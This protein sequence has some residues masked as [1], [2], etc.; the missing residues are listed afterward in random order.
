[1]EYRYGV[2][3]KT[4]ETVVK[5]AV[6]SGTTVVY[7]GT[8]PV[9][10]IRGYTDVVNTPVKLSN[11]EN[12][13]SRIGFSDDWENF[14][15]SEAV[16]AHFNN[17]K[18]NVG[19]VYAINVLDPDTHRKKEQTTVS[20]AFTNKKAY[21]VS[22]TIILDTLA[23]EGMTEGKD[24]SVSYSYGK[25]TV[26]IT[27]LTSMEN[28][29]ATYY[30]VNT[31]MIEDTDIIGEYTDGT[32]TGLKAVK[33]IYS[34]FNAVTN[35][36]AVPKWSEKQSVYLEMCRSS[37]EINGHWNA[38]ALAD[39]PVSEGTISAAVSWKSDNGYQ[40]ENSKVFWPKAKGID[41]KIYHLST[42]AAVEFLRTDNEHNGIPM[43]TCGNKKVPMAAQWFGK[44]SNNN[45]FD[46]EE[47]KE[48]TSKGISTLVF[49]G[50]N[51]VLW[52]DHTAQYEFGKE[53]DARAI[54]DVS[55]RMLYYCTN[56]F[57]MRHGEDIDEPFTVNL[58][59]SILEEEQTYLDALVADGALIGEP[60]IEF[61]ES[62]NSDE[63]ILNGDF[64]FDLP[65]TPTPPLKSAT[66]Y[67]S[68]TDAGFSVYTESEGDE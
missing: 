24:Y 51:Y 52:G 28:V 2:Y 33:L 49:W 32:C 15:L 64:R 20:L 55:I 6:Q 22:D 45:G 67:V 4:G 46:Q 41:G 60:K 50:G 9:N 21:I 30:E 44:S 40:M 62:S 38:F 27:A 43:E 12:A 1:M 63:D 17:L 8:S 54:F 19:P 34:M 65:V 53:M 58:K 57:Q 11:Y 18:G 29:N 47:S 5:S 59:D 16:E 66:I 26:V 42:L 14:T 36:I 39:I 23:L 61:I 48:L 35:I 31:D 7:V 25:K 10:L 37:K 56:G 13:V 68:Y 3:G